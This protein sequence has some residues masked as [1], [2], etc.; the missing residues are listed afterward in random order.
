MGMGLLLAAIGLG[1]AEP[2]PIVGLWSI[3]ETRNC[4]SGLAWAFM[5]DGYYVEVKLPD[6]GPDAAGLWKDEGSAIA[7]THSHMPFADMLQPNA[8]KR[9]TIE[10]RTAD[11]IVA[12]SYRGT[13]RIFHRCPPEALKA[14]PGQAEH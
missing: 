9:L 1:A 5:A 12:R 4:T 14:P 3:G 6:Q 11:R 7:Y 2:A 8:M 10:A 13:E